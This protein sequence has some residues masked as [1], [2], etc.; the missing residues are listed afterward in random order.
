MVCSTTAMHAAE[1]TVPTI[2]RAWQLDKW[3]GVADTLAGIDS[4]Y[5]DYPMRDRL[6]D[7][8]ISNV[9][10]SNLISPSQSRI[11]FNRKNRFSCNNNPRTLRAFKADCSCKCYFALS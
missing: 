2:I 3:T 8:S 5:I 9:T 1:K 6:N 11:Y 10:N 4:S 7:Y